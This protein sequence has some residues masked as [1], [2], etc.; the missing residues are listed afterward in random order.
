MM[1]QIVA[2][3]KVSQ[4]WEEFVRMWDVVCPV[5][6]DLTVVSPVA[7]VRSGEAPVSVALNT[8]RASLPLTGWAHTTSHVRTD[9]GG[10]VCTYGT[11]P[12][13]P[14]SPSSALKS[15]SWRP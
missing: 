3:M 12:A 15:G 13:P 7:W 5:P 11:S 8:T 9:V 6:D 1:I 10:E 2:I 4:S 14:T